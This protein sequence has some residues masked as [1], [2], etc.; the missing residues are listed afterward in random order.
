MNRKNIWRRRDSAITPEE[1]W[2][3]R[4][5][6]LAGLA[7]AGLLPSSILD[8]ALPLKAS[9]RQDPQD[10]DGPK[11]FRAPEGTFPATRNKSYAVDERPL[12]DEKAATS[13]NNFYEFSLN[14]RMVQFKVNKFQTAPWKVEIAG[15][16]EKPGIAD[17]E[18]FFKHLR[19]EERIYRFRCVEAWSM[20]VPWTGFPM[21]KFLEWVAPTKDAR[22]VQMFTAYR[23][24]EMPDAVRTGYEFPYYEALSLAEAGNELSLL[25]HGLYG[26]ELPRQNGAPLRLVTPWKY[27]LKSIKSVVKFEFTKEKPPTFWNNAQP[28]E[29]SWHS[30]VEPNVPHPRWSQAEERLIPGGEKV[31]TLPY[32]G[33][34]D[35]VAKLYEK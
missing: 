34:A 28:K 9:F 19:S 24:D 32:N 20:T 27:G 30:N 29:Y 15:L 8:R 18:D 12:T 23:P 1:A 7:A 5:Q 13:Y 33:Y 4:R 3:N 35:L 11:L 10:E 6:V 14:K 25:A 16:V 2:V 22:Y 31:K 26:K 21:K 17:L